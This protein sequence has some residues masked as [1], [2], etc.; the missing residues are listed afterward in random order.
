MAETGQ[1]F[2]ESWYRI[3]NQRISLR[4]GVKVTRQNFRGERWYVLED[5]F[6][7]Q[8][9]RVRPP[10]YEF[11]ARLSPERTVQEV[12]QECLER[13]PDEAPGQEAVIQLLSQLYHANL[14]Q[15]DFATDSAQLFERYKKRRQRETTARLQQV[16]FMR[17]PLFDPDAFLVRTLPLVGK[18]ISPIG[19][20][21]WSIVV[22]AAIKVGLDNFAALKD[23]TE[24]VLSPAN[25][26]LLYACMVIVKTLH[27]F[28]HAYFC[29]KFGGE[30]HTMG[31]M[32][33]IFTPVP[34]MDATSSW[35]FRSR[36]Q[37][38]LVGGA[39]MIVEIFIA[40]IAMF[41][42]AKTGQGTLHS[43]AYNIVFIA[44]VSTIIFN[45]NPLLRFDGY[46]MLS[47]ALDIPN[48]HQRAGAH[49]RHLVEHYLFGVQ[50]SF[51]PTTSRREKTWLTVFGISSNI[52]RVI[53]FA[54]ILLFIA[55]KFLLI[56]IVM[57][58]VCAVSW[59]VV[60]LVKFVQYLAA[61]PKLERT[62]PRAIGV[63]LAFVSVLL[64]FLQLVPFPNHFR[65]PG[66]VE[67]R[68]WTQVV[69]D[70]SGNVKTILAKPGSQVT[71]GEP[72]VELQNPEL[73]LQLAAARANHAEVEARWRF[74][75]Q[76]DIA[77][78]KPMESR[79]QSALKRIKYL[80]DEKANL[81]VRAR[82]SGIWVAPGIQDYR[83][84]WLARGT[85]LGL[86]IDPSGFEFTA[87]VRQDDA[88]RLFA[89]EDT[90]A[91]V[92]L[93]GEVD[94]VVRL[95]KLRVIPGEQ[96]TLPSAAL[97]WGSGGEMAVAMDDPQGKRAAEP[98]FAV[99][100]PIEGGEDVALLHGRTGKIRFNIGSE[101]LLPR[102]IRRFRQLLQKRYQI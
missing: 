100:A 40:A 84:R 90:T 87:T 38:I 46:Y 62:R 30:V 72:L 50:K 58:A 2:S 19:A 77:S 51:S 75:M 3:A 99:V 36:T 5:P 52:Y 11:V 6:S 15:Y 94:T 12:W 35:S 83:G 31:V 89:R 95:G 53:V 21:L 23:N 48:L 24:A 71:Q 78:L 45:I 32:L 63:T 18:L 85:P 60:P 93:Y 39:G 10:A 88:D 28:G 16:M 82:Q 47:D 91:E 98:F 41:V 97:G 54:G 9:F 102:W 26:P 49:L 17:I 101:P 57:A 59:V 44:S 34:Y 96:H 68:Q 56:G 27:E 86:L 33:L 81:I 80:E 22:L 69:N 70:A 8:F 61:S 74:A 67:A 64:I 43:I 65:A 66:V 13:F 92:R 55:D 1:T 25:I 7:N 29:R 76:S 79:L 4:H 42:W 37:R 14:L 20:V 73:D